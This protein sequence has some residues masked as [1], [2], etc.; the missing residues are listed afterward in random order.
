VRVEWLHFVTLRAAADRPRD[1]NKSIYTPLFIMDHSVFSYLRSVALIGG[2]VI[3]LMA[4]RDHITKA[5]AASVL[6][7][8]IVIAGRMAGLG[9]ALVGATVAAASFL[10]Y[11]LPPVGFSIRDPNDW[12]SLVAFIVTALIAGSMS[13]RTNRLMQQRD[14]YE[15]LYWTLYG[16]TSYRE[17]TPPPPPKSSQ[18]VDE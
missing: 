7:L 10:Y 3:L 4:T 13:G 17:A 8:S 1:V 11:F 2:T 5:S 18:L 15:R 16:S 9:P 12:I 14:H 6:L